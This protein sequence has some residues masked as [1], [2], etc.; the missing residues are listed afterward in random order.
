M[1]I[2]LVECERVTKIYELYFYNDVKKLH[3]PYKIYN[4]DSF[5]IIICNINL[6]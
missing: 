6:Q 1:Y 3:F 2:S 4:C 5:I